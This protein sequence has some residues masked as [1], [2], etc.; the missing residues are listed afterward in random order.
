[1]NSLINLGGSFGLALTAILLWRRPPPVQPSGSQLHRGFLAAAVVFVTFAAFARAFAIY[2]LSDDFVLIRYASEWT[3][4]R[5]VPVFT[6]AGGDGFFRPIGYIQMGLDALWAGSSAAAWHTGALVLHAANSLL[7]ML[8]AERLGASRLAGFYAAVLFAIHGTRP[9]AAVWIAGRFDLL[10]TL[11]LLAAFLLFPRLP[12]VSLLCFVLAVLS[13]ESAYVLPVWLTLCEFVKRRRRWGALIPFWFTAAVLLAYRLALF[14]GIGGYPFSLSAGPTL[15]AVGVRLWA[16]LYFP[17]NWSTQ[18]ST[19]LLA[20]GVAYVAALIWTVLRTRPAGRLWLPL[21]FLL[22][23]ILPVLPLLGIGPQLANAR[24]LY[25]PSAAFCVLLAMAVDGLP[26]RARYAAA[27]AIALFHLAALQH[28]L[29]AWEYAS[30]Q[31]RAFCIA[32]AGSAPTQIRGVPALANGREEC[33]A[34]ARR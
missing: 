26:V 28:N 29:D 22:T 3:P 16:A 9:E 31:V 30:R 8:A 18:P 19:L 12:A 17:I 32:G 20:L 15:K 5:V 7:V 6:T 25:L 13:K 21:L 2:F 33:I 10:A 27:G 4:S 14:H 24:V 23:G 1:M 11:F 34:L